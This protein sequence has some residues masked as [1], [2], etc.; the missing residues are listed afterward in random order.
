M[1]ELT[2]ELADS[3]DTGLMCI[4]HDTV[5][6]RIR[7]TEWIAE[8]KGVRLSDSAVVLIDHLSKGPLRVTELGGLVGASSPTIT[9]QV[10][11]L[12]KKGLIHKTPDERDGRATIVSLSPLGFDI[13]GRDA[14]GFP[15]H[16]PKRLEHPGF[17]APIRTAQTNGGRPE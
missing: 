5:L 7:I 13:C 12:E 3:I 17:A 2:E 8:R 15:A 16:F 9:K 11:D 6:G 10:R 4:A 1:D 14:Q